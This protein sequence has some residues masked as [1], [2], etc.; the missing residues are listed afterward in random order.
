M[1][2]RIKG[3]SIVEYALIIAVVAAALLAVNI[4][5][6]RGVQGK[7]RETSD[8][9]G[10]QFETHN[11]MVHSVRDRSGKTVEAASSGVIDVYNNGTMGSTAD[12]S[13][14]YGNESVGT[15]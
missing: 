2:K 3:Q 13:T 12:T 7:L 15:W 1:L 14:T 9:I 5:V 4:Y 6:K 10:A 11:T 8:D